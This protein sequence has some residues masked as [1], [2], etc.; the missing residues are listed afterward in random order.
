MVMIV[1]S[2][3]A[4]V[5]VLIVGAYWLVVVLPEGRGQSA[6]RRRLKWQDPVQ[7]GVD[8]LKKQDVLSTIDALNAVLK[9]LG[10]FSGP[11]KVTLDQSGVPLTVGSFLLLS[12]TLGVTVALLIQMYTGYRSIGLLV[13]GI[14]GVF[15]L[16]IV[17]HLRNR[18]ILLFESQFP[19]A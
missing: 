14:V 7:A 8:L 11:L 19:E 18:R 10:G 4:G 16:G 9:R 6:L 5:F 12:L 1:A 3:F 17:R 2:L 13:G 15:P